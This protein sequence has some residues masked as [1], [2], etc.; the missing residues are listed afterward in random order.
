MASVEWGFAVKHEIHLHCI[1]KYSRSQFRPTISTLV[2]PIVTKRASIGVSSGPR[3]TVYGVRRASERDASVT[4]SEDGGG[5]ELVDTDG[6]I[7]EESEDESDINGM[8]RQ[9]RDYENWQMFTAEEGARPTGDNE[10][11]SEDE[12]SAS[13][14]RR[15][16]AEEALPSPDSGSMNWSAADKEKVEALNAFQ[17]RYTILNIL[18]LV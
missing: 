7:F 4:T 13:S 1:P 11:D 15:R 2:F 10:T 9:S 8:L 5:L 12:L 3:R 16:K 17:H 6:I 14:V 18:L